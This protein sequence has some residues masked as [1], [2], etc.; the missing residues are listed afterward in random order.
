VS[1][2]AFQVRPA[3]RSA[4]DLVVA[5]SAQQRAPYEVIG[6]GEIPRSDALLMGFLSSITLWRRGDA[7]LSGGVEA[8]D[9]SGIQSDSSLV[10]AA[11][12]DV[13][14]SAT[15]ARQSALGEWSAGAALGAGT[16]TPNGGASTAT[17]RF[18]LR[19][20]WRPR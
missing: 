17:R 19:A 13:A 10:A 18:T 20:G 2:F 11:F 6:I 16:V 14:V 8:R 9:Y 7:R 15:Y 5:L 12:R 3:T 4:R 1:S